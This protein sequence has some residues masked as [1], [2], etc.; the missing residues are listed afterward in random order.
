MKS[1]C[2][3]PRPFTEEI[4]M[5]APIHSYIELRQQ[6]H[7]DLRLQHP[8][9]VEP[10]GGC[11]TCDSYELRLVELLDLGH[12]PTATRPSESS[13]PGYAGDD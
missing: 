13:R 6:I 7:D 11:P 8:D 9:W 5:S 1:N 3:P 2:F 10:D 12:R 4:T